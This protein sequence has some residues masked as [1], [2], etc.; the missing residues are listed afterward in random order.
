MTLGGK[1][2]WI[3]TNGLTESQREKMKKNKA[4]GNRSV[5]ANKSKTPLGR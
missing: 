3:K 5:T 2:R 1:N 4:G